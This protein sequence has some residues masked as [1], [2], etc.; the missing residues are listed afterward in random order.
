MYKYMYLYIVYFAS[1][2]SSTSF[3]VFEPNDEMKNA[4]EGPTQLKKNNSIQILYVIQFKN[5][6]LHNYIIKME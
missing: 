4:F 6:H 3:S 1:F 2:G 5:L